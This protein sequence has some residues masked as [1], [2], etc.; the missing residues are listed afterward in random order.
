MTD[1]AEEITLHMAHRIEDKLHSERKVRGEKQTIGIEI[2]TLL[3]YMDQA[4]EDDAQAR[5]EELAS[6]ILS[7]NVDP[8]TEI[9]NFAKRMSVQYLAYHYVL[10]RGRQ[11][12]AS[13]EI[14]SD[15]GDALADLEQR[16]GRSI[17]ADINTIDAA[18]SYGKTANEITHFQAAYENV[19]RLEVAQNR[20]EAVLGDATLAKTL[21]LALQSFGTKRIADG[22]KALTSALG[23]DLSATR[24]SVSKPW[25]HALL[26]NMF[27]VQSAVSVL[28]NCRNLGARLSKEVQA[29]FDEEKLMKKIVETVESS[30]LWPQTFSSMPTEFGVASLAER[31]TFL[32]G[33]RGIVRDLPVQLFVSDDARTN[34]LEAVQIAYEEAVQEEL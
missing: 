13:E 18:A 29:G 7:G 5:L 21:S 22:L 15:L 34:V 26:S 33:V 32:D 4:R 16:A 19:V 11:Q 17:R 24:S 9:A 3:S 1:S 23:L 20:V 8:R 30:S 31:L 27:H 10:Q 28:E 25:L 12:N 6:R 2:E 14:L